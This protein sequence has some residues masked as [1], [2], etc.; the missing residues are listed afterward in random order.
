MRG[1]RARRAVILI[2]SFG[3]NAQTGILNQAGGR[4]PRLFCDGA[5][6]LTMRAA[7]VLGVC[8]IVW[9]SPA[10]ADDARCTVTAVNMVTPDQGTVSIDCTEVSEAFGRQFADVLTRILKDRLDPQTVMAKL[11]EVEQV[12]EEGVAR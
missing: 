9:A 12:P 1:R 4:M 2:S 8:W 5:A 10:R 6:M 11:D 7:I 3:R